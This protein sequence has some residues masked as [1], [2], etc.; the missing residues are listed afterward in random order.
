[1][2]DASLAPAEVSVPQ[3]AA[4]RVV[5]VGGG[6]AAAA[7]A[8]TF[9]SA[10]VAFAA[11]SGSDA[12]AGYLNG[13][14]PVVVFACDDIAADGLTA[15]GLATASAGVPLVLLASSA[16]GAE[17]VEEWWRAGVSDCL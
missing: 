8:A 15:V 11:V 10:G 13:R 12:L 16:P 7:A 3:R 14:R 6:A 4:D 1:M 17:Q 5:V 2:L 9:T